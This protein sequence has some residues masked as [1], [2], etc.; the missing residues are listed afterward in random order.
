MIT[1]ISTFRRRC[2][3]Q[4]G[5]Q[6]LFLIAR[7]AHRLTPA[8][9]YRLAHLLGW[10]MPRLAKRQ[11][12]QVLADVSQVFGS[13]RSPE[14]ILQLVQQIFYHQG[15]SV[16]EFFRLPHFTAEEIRGWAPLEGT[17]YLD[18]AL[19]LGHGAILLTAHLGNW[20]VCGTVMGLQSVSDDGDCQYTG[21]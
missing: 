9:A 2:E 20:E 16:L 21:R 4:F 10:L 1:P 6:C 14:D 17:E 3:S 13:E 11:Y 15:E 19:A 8:Q 7:I 18:A 5:T 12:R